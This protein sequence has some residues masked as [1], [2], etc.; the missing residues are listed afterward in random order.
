[1]KWLAM[2]N[3]QEQIRKLMNDAKSNPTNIIN[4]GVTPFISSPKLT[5]NTN[6]QN[7]SVMS[8]TMRS[9]PQTPP[10][11]PCKKGKNN[12]VLKSN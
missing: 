12:V 3:T 2:S 11:S 8:A 6:L 1:M 9:N 4:Q 5:V 7:S 10:R